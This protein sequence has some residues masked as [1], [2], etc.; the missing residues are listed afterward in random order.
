[1]KRDIMLLLDLLNIGEKIWSCEPLSSLQY[2]IN[3][4]L[5]AIWKELFGTFIT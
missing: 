2:N 1:M 5:N 4:Q 3:F